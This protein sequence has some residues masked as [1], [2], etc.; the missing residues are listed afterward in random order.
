MGVERRGSGGCGFF[1][2]VFGG[3]RSRGVG[4]SG[5][6]RCAWWRSSRCGRGC[7]GRGGRGGRRWRL[8]WGRRGGAQGVTWLISQCGWGSVAAG[9]GAAA[10]AGEHRQ[11]LLF[12]EQPLL[13]AVGGD[14]S[15]LGQQD[16]D[17]FGLRVQPPLGQR[18]RD[19]VA[20]RRWW[21]R[22]CR[23]PNS[24]AV[25]GQH[26]AWWRTPPAFGSRPDAEQHLPRRPS[27]ASWRR[28]PGVRSVA[29]AVLGVG[30]LRLARGVSST[31][32]TYSA[33]S[34]VR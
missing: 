8:T 25:H 12:G 33:A 9:P 2:R 10:V 15:G 16:Q 19:G 7:G 29:R 34:A 5:G 14:C 11:A 4:C 26:D 1:G 23:W 27:S 3:G 32:W 6:C 30:G 24:S 31:V 20:V 17:G 22:R 28:W 13:V 21:R 18:N